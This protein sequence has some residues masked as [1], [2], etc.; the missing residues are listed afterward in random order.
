MITLQ[1][2]RAFAT[3]QMMALEAIVADVYTSRC[4][5]LNSFVLFDGGAHR[6]YHTLRMLG[7]KGCHKVIAV[8]ADPFM[9]AVL[10]KT[11]EDA[12]DDVLNRVELVESALQNNPRV[13]S[14]TWKSS[15][16][17]VGRSS[18]SGPNAQH[19]TIWPTDANIA[20]RPDLTVRATTIDKTLAT[21]GRPV[22]FLKL[23][24]EGADLL[25]LFGAERTL[26]SKRP[27]IAFENALHAPK[28]HGF[29]LENVI[30]YLSALDY[31]PLD[32]LGKPL[33]PATWF[34]FHEA[35][36]VPREQLAQTQAQLNAAL[37]QQIKTP[38]PA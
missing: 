37:A 25:A 7:L 26:H 35:W 4:A 6:G 11:L 32:F 27:L 31:V 34:G 19:R 29:S 9:A 18:I 16:S 13:Y 36:V 8:E 17:H 15:T 10:L 2:F 20:Y 21:V 24:L 1:E 12:G 3:S 33:T 23:D 30:S 22:P 38:I 28:V 14:L 5:P